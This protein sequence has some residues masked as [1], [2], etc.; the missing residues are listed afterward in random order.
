MPP[1]NEPPL[2]IL[3]YVDMDSYKIDDSDEGSSITLMIAGELKPASPT[4]PRYEE[5]EKTPLS[6]IIDELNETFKTD[7]TED[8]KV[9]FEQLFTKVLNNEELGEKVEHNSR[10]NVEAIF[11][12]YFDDAMN[13]LLDSHFNFYKKINDDENLKKQIKE[14][15][16]KRV[17]DEREVKV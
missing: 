2:D 10:E 12:Q 4:G 5:D 13:D 14:L 6:E 8:D 16:L 11:D 9:N 15:L 1:D 7:F 17:Y 3:R